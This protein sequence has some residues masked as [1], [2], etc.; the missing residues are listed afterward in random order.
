MHSKIIF[1][2]FLESFKAFTDVYCN[3]YMEWKVEAQ[4]QDTTNDGN[5]CLPSHIDDIKLDELPTQLE[6]T[7]ENSVKSYHCN[8]SNK[9]FAHRRPLVRHHK[10]HWVKNI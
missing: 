1:K 2:P 7:I 6:Q 8:E 10:T 5:I 9:Y 4:Q 3:N